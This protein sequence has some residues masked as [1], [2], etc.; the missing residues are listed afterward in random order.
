MAEI[1]DVDILIAIAAE[2]GAKNPSAVGG[3]VYGEYCGHFIGLTY[4]N[5]APLTV[6][7]NYF[8]NWQGFD[9]LSPTVIE[10]IG[11][12]LREHSFKDIL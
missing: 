3:L 2:L 8:F 5:A 1:T 10:D 6:M 7:V 4:K 11:T 9:L 12:W